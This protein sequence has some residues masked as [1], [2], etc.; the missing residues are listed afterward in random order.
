ME[1]SP[2]FSDEC[3][4]VISQLILIASKDSIRGAYIETHNLRYQNVLELEHS[5]I[6]LFHLLNYGFS[7]GN[8]Y[9]T[10]IDSLFKF[11]VST[12]GPKHANNGNL[13]KKV[14]GLLDNINLVFFNHRPPITNSLYSQ[15]LH[16]IYHTLKFILVKG[17]TQ[18]FAFLL[19]HE[20]RLSK[21]NTVT[22][23]SLSLLSGKRMLIK[24]FILCQE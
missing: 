14:R 6:T 16:L 17:C 24:V 20:V 4:N 23:H 5:T 19:P 21:K 10:T 7:K 12:F 11:Q 15:K 22:C 3:T 13:Y 2:S 18:C 1:W 8:P 9:V